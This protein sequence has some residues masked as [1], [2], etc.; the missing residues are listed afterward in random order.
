M[1]QK[2][3]LLWLFFTMV[4]I[5]FSIGQ[6]SVANFP[7][8]MLEIRQNGIYQLTGKAIQKAGWNLAELRKNQLRLFLHGKEIAF[9]VSN[10]STSFLPTDTLLFYGKQNLGE[11]DTLL[12]ATGQ[13]ANPFVSLFKEANYY[14]LTHSSEEKGKQIKTMTYHEHAPTSS[15][16]IQKDR[17]VFDTSYSTNATIGLVPILQQSTWE[18]GEGWSDIPRS[19]DTTNQGTFLLTKT[20]L[21]LDTVHVCLRLAGRSRVWHELRVQIANQFQDIT[22]S[23]YGWQDVYINIPAHEVTR[24][25]IDWKITSLQKQPLDWFS[26]SFV[27]V[28]YAC[29]F[30]NSFSIDEEVRFPPKSSYQFLLQPSSHL[31]DISNPDSPEIIESHNGSSTTLFTSNEKNISV[32]FHTTEYLN[33]LSIR[34]MES[35]ESP[36][37]GTNLV[38]ITTKHL[39]SK[40]REYAAYRASI[41]GGSYIPFLLTTEQIRDNY[42]FGETSPWMIQKALQALNPQ[43]TE[44]THV[45]LV[46]RGMSFPGKIANNQQENLVPTYGYPASDLLLTSDLKAIENPLPLFPIG[47]LPVMEEEEL[48]IYLQK[49]KAYEQQEQSILLQKKILHL[50]GGRGTLEREQ[51]KKILQNVA[52]MT[53]MG[54]LSPLFWTKN[55]STNEEIEKVNIREELH[56]GVGMVTFLGHGASSYLDF[57][58][59]FV[60][61]PSNQIDNKGKYPLLFFNGCGVGNIFNRRETL[62]TDWLLTEDKGAIAVLAHSFWSFLSPTETYLQALYSIIFNEEI[63][64]D[65]TIG[66]MQL[67]AYRKLYERAKTDAYLRANIQQIILQGDPTLVLFRKIKPDL[68][69][70]KQSMY[71]QSTTLAKPI[72][73]N[74]SMYLV[75]PIQNRAKYRADTKYSVAV[76]SSG[77]GEATHTFTFP[78]STYQD[79]L[80]LPISTQ[81]QPRQLLVQINPD[82]TFEEFTY[83]NNEA[84]LELPDFQT[85][86]KLTT[87]P[88]RLYKDKTPPLLYFSTSS[89]MLQSVDTLQTNSFLFLKLLDNEPLDTTHA[90]ELIQV[91][92]RTCPTCSTTALVSDQIQQ[93]SSRNI[94]FRY[95]LQALPS[96]LYEFDAQ[97][98]DSNGNLSPFLQNTFY[99]KEIT[100]PFVRVS[101]NPFGNYLHAFWKIDGNDAGSMLEII[102]M[103]GKIIYSQHIELEKQELFIDTKLWIAGSYIM[104]LKW[105]N[106]QNEWQS[107]RFLVQ[108]IR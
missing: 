103:Q 16:A 81:N 52:D 73:A 4:A 3:I 80:V 87:Y 30:P 2:C 98:K 82:R 101:P 89:K 107:K 75:V 74:D 86:G 24:Q 48:A 83:E 20:P 26:F 60:S 37:V 84:M 35:L 105:K 76:T 45:F 28:Q 49:V 8:L 94:T 21:P 33:P 6:H 59:G 64:I 50:S 66:Q 32:L 58:I 96:G 5:H 22:V 17:L 25:R 77:V 18:A 51:L 97:G 62:T 38:F 23:P 92:Y 42:G 44:N 78:I 99:L 12:Y 93:A 53:K 9:W 19:T 108:C 72:E 95:P 13:R 91:V 10:P 55:K 11:L 57:D 15:V 79:T 102:D 106:T 41:Q 65:P 7:P 70:E 47:R 14:Y 56:K 104:H 29:P 100:E 69:I 71:V 43:L 90:R 88:E 1:K 63:S 68:N 61:N 40:T 46:G 31:W 67:I 39:L 85:Y 54:A 34:T 27:Q 36:K